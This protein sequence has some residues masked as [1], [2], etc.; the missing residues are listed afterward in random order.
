MLD[1]IDFTIW[2]LG[3]FVL[4]KMLLNRSATGL[5]LGNSWSFQVLLL[6]F[7]SQDQKKS[8]LRPNLLHLQ[9]QNPLGSLPDV[10]WSTRFSTPAAEN[11]SMWSCGYSLQ[12]LWQSSLWPWVVPYTNWYSAETLRETVQISK[13]LSLSMYLYSSNPFPALSSKLVVYLDFQLCLL[14]SD[15]TLALFV[16]PPCNVMT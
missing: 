14:H 9:G 12:S 6:S 1:T 2:V 11:S 5:L 10:P 15:R 3:V 16:F 8:Y 13:T 7:I 4:L